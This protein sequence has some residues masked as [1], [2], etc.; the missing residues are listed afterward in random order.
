MP[1]YLR[2]QQ[3][4]AINTGFCRQFHAGDKGGNKTH[5]PR[6]IDKCARCASLKGVTLGLCSTLFY[7]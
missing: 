6:A 2:Y 1:K 7:S 4:T 5:R 3:K